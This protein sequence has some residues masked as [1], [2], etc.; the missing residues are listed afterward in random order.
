M[1]QIESLPVDTNSRP[2]Q[3]AKIVKC[4]ELVR[5]VKGIIVINFNLAVFNTFTSAKKEK[6]KKK[7]ENEE[8]E[9]TSGDEKKKK[10]HKKD[11]KKE[12]KDKKNK[13]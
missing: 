7:E 5:Q 8:E 12:K 1:R 3:D 6:K 9:A 13:E 2:L 4:G 11:K 10:K